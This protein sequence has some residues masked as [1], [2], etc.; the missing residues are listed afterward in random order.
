MTLGTPVISTTCSGMP[1]LLKDRYNA[2]LV[3]PRDSRAIANAILNFSQMSSDEIAQ[4]T[5]NAQLLVKQRLLWEDQIH[6]YIR[7][8]EN[9]LN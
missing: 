7:L 3:P 4:I 5:T 8:Y 6:N 9:S 2:L 1:E